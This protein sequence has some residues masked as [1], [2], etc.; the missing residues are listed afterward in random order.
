MSIVVEMKHICKVYPNG[1]V[2]NDGVDFVVHK[3]EIHALI[4]E[5][6]AGKS[7]LM[8]I[9]YGLFPQTSGDL[10]INGK[11]RRFS[12]PRDAIAAGV[13]MIHQH[14]MLIPSFTVAQN[15]VLGFEPNK[16]G[17]VDE[18][19]AVEITKNLSK[20]FGLKVEPEALVKHISVGMQQRVEILK[21]L[22][23]GADILI[24]DEPTAVLTP[25]ETKDLF[26]SIRQLVNLGKT[27]I[28]I[29]HKLNEVQEV[30]ERF[31]IMRRGKHVMA[32]ETKG[33]TREQMAS[34]M[35]GREVFL[36]TRKQ[37]CRPGDEVLT[38]ENLSYMDEQGVARLQHINFS[39]RA[40]EIVGIAGVEGNGQTELVEII[41]GLRE[42]TSGSVR[43][44][45]QELLGKTPRQIRNTGLG[46][47]P[48]NRS[49]NGYAAKVTIEENL[50]IDRYWRPPFSRHLQMNQ[51]H[52]I[53]NAKRMI[54]QFDIRVQDGKQL[55][56]ECSGG[57]IQKVII[58]RELSS[59]VVLLI[60]AQPTRGV[61]VGATEYIRDLIMQ[62][63]TQGMAV[64]LGFQDLSAD[65]SEVIDLSDR[66]VT[67]FEGTITGSFNNDPP[68]SEEE[69]GLYML[70]IRRQQGEHINA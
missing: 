31:T 24:L 13:G 32:M 36:Q 59:D 35:V 66:I 38:V 41:S 45:G 46:H 69:V 16:K 17:F 3:G 34:Y 23:Q 50:I 49:S 20:Q 26:I 56:G 53:N 4:G 25:Q 52:I 39:I 19:A 27:V 60:A 7:T 54:E 65:L 14:F 42:A 40:G 62:Q 58:A 22:Y 48:E 37:P 1:V 57:N 8:H 33:V 30:S 44:H 64:L 5:N 67:V 47:I 6:G 61:D 2:A 51:E 63:R 29:T 15:V 43:I 28:F 18:D 55:A 12:S 9:L 11:A 70:G 21:L 10:I 68:I